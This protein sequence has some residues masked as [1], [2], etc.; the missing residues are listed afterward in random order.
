MSEET[1]IL[2]NKFVNIIA[3]LRDPQGGCP[4]DLKQ[5][6]ESLRP[7]IVE[8]AYE[9]IDAVDGGDDKE[10]CQELGD[11]LLQVVL[12]ARIA[13]QRG[14]FSI[15]DVISSVS[16]K[17][18]RRHPHV[19]G[20]VS[21]SDANEVVKNWEQIKYKERT[22]QAKGLNTSSED[23]F[24]ET[25]SLL[26]GVP[27]ALPAL[28]QAE[29][30]GEKA[31]RVSFDWKNVSQ[32][33]EKVKE[34]I[35]ELECEV[36]YLSNEGESKRGFNRDAI[37]HEIGD[38]LF[39]LCQLSRW[40][41]LSAEDCLRSCIRRFIARFRKMEAEL[42]EKIASLGSEDLEKAWQKAKTE[43]GSA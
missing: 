23:N 16:E 7:Y 22:E 26:S 38:V 42:G 1:G 19:F 24:P 4:W 30:L 6:H 25:P 31:A 18:L 36:G 34:E 33:F 12:H 21:V 35:S 8:E 27:S 32:V 40:L 13:E 17:M 39:S 14:A 2:F 9:M 37:E 3:R 11:V 5:T 20:N 43:L 29:R 41:D 28:L 10:L 15:G